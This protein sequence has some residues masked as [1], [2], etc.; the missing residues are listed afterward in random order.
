[1]FVKVLERAAAER[2]ALKERIAALTE[3]V[4]E[5]TGRPP[6]NVHITFEPAAEGRQSFG[7]RLVE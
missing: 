7:G 1:M 6:E 5:T 2:G 3:T 4:A